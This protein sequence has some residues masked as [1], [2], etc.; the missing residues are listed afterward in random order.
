MDTGRNIINWLYK[1]QL[2]VDKKWSVFLKDEFTWWADQNRQRIRLVGTPKI[3]C[4]FII[5]T[6]SIETDFLKNIELNDK[7]LS[8]INTFISSKL[9]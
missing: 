7:N 4:E 3:D 8:I 6:I 9:T 1:D 2:R 5:H